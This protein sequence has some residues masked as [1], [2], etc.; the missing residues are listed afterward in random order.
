MSLRDVG[1]KSSES[2]ESVRH[3]HKQIYSHVTNKLFLESITP[4]ARLFAFFTFFISLPNRLD[5]KYTPSAAYRWR[6]SRKSVEVYFSNLL[7]R[8]CLNYP[9]DSQS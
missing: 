5:S 8:P 7:Y 9:K 4:L 1:A 6:C 3:S 2:V